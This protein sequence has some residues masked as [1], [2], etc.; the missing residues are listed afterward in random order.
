MQPK[1]PQRAAA[2]ASI[3]L[4]LQI[5]KAKERRKTKAAN[6]AAKKARRAAR[7]R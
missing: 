2:Q 6:R 1:L 7:K 3:L 5:R 4:E